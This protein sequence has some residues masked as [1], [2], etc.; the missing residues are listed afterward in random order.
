M[1]TQL[2][3][4]DT[5]LDGILAAIELNDDAAIMA[6]TGQADT[7]ASS[8]KGLPKLSINYHEDSDDG[9]SIPK[10]DWR[11]NDGTGDVYAPKV[12]IRPLFRTYNWSVWDE[13]TT[14]FSAT[15]IQRPTI[16]GDFPDSTGGNKCGRLAKQEEE[17]LSDDDPRVLLS[18][19]VTCNQIIYGIIDVKDGV[20]ADGS[21]AV[22]EGMPFVAY[23]KKSGFIPVRNFI[24]QELKRKKKVLMQ[25]SYIEL[26]TEK[27]KKGTLTY[28]T[29]KLAFV[30]EVSMSDSDKSLIKDFTSTVKGFNEKI[31]GDYTS[32]TK[33]TLSDADADMSKRFG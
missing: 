10:G 3:T 32:A 29:P 26:T 17:T 19:S 25:K 20:Y 9:H 2:T 24:D 5:E 28:F 6:A 31:M 15:S 13:E 7:T 27:Q 21:A 22:I 16:S 23:F 12:F 14:K 11:I 8:N 4:I 30:K 1:G 33:A 18:R